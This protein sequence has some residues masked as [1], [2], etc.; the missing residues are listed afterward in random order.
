MN[1]IIINVRHK[2]MELTA[3]R[4]HNV[5]LFDLLAESIRDSDEEV[6]IQLIET[7]DSKALRDLEKYRLDDKDDDPTTD[8][9]INLLQLAAAYSVSRELLCLLATKAPGLLSLGRR[10]P[11]EGQ[12]ALHTLISKEN[13]QVVDAILSQH[14]PQ[15]RRRLLTL[16]T[17]TVGGAT[18]F[19][20]SGRRFSFVFERSYSGASAFWVSGC[21]F[22]FVFERS[23]SGASVFWV[24]GHRFSFVFELSYSSASVFWVS[25]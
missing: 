1:A 22:S 8:S 18:V 13:V 14:S 17:V 4:P 3:S 21:R 11:Y 16:T 10:Y 6:A 5:Q 2:T 23:Y 20:V 25:F 19:C 15:E 12:T 9:D 7:L 24:Y